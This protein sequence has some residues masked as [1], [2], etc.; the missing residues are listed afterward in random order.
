MNISRPL[1]QE[2]SGAIQAVRSGSDSLLIYML[3]LV[4]I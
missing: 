4:L 1:E 3:T 2:R